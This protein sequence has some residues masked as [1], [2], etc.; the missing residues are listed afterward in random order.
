MSKVLITGGNQFVGQW[1]ADYF[2]QNHE[3][4]SASRS[5][6]YDLTTA[7]S[8]Q[9]LLKLSEEVDIF[10]N[11]VHVGDSQCYLLDS[12]FR[13]WQHQNK[14]II[15]VGTVELPDEIW[16]LVPPDYREQKMQLHAL[17]AR[18]Q[19]ENNRKCHLTNLRLGVMNTENCKPL[20][21]PKVEKSELHQA[22]D[23]LCKNRSL[24]ITDLGLGKLP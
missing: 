14:W 5:S 23:F 21:P 12:F 17:V 8:R 13:K 24:E 6:G 2:Q 19:A 7:E 9:S 3:V 20:S 16:N 1:I 4:L 15:N 18:L 11:N 10:V 22:L